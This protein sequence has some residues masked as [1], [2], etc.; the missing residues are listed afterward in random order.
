MVKE[1]K[2]NLRQTIRQ[3]RQGLSSN[4]RHQ[5]NRQIAE[6]LTQLKEFKEAKSILFY[7]SMPEEVA[8]L[9][10]IESYLEEKQI[11]LPRTENNQLVLHHLKNIQHLQKGEYDI[12][13]PILD[14]DVVDPSTVDLAIIPGL[15]FDEQKNRLGFGK[16]YYDKL[17]P[18]IRCPKLGLAYECQIVKDVPSEDHDHPLDKI[19]T[20]KRIIQ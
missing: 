10:I 9:E 19:V 2:Q 15:A 5:A 4:E 12:L 14:L 16:G 20:E 11:I 13:E 8:T 3:A 6:K 17:L 7:A 1:L 18:H